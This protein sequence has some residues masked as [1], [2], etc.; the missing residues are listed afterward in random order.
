M[1]GNAMPYFRSFRARGAPYTALP[2][3]FV[4]LA[5]GCFDSSGAVKTV[6]VAGKITLN[7]KS[8]TAASTIVLFKP[9]TGR[10]NTSLF[11]PAG[12]VDGA[13]N[14]QVST[15]GKPG[16]PPGWYKVIV[17]ATEPRRPE[18]KGPKNHRPGPRS[19]LPARYG[20]AATTTVA[21]EVVERPAAGAY[22]V[23]LTSK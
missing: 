9:D 10:G 19:V 4:F 23:K 12:S 1:Q 18:E 15:K 22:D 17:T 20:Q 6:P 11:E 7:D 14:Y 2:L 21:I 5:S 3:F 13:G 16:A 8:V